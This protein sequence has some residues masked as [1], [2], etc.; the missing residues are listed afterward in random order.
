M[1]LS[2]WMAVSAS[3]AVSPSVA[4]SS[5]TAITLFSSIMSV[6]VVFPRC[7]TMETEAPLYSISP[8]IRAAAVFSASRRVTFSSVPAERLPDGVLPAVSPDPERIRARTSAFVP[9]S[10]IVSTSIR[11]SR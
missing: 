3:R 2:P 4:P 8:P 11:L 1:I 10:E 7:A 6:R 9:E 5:S